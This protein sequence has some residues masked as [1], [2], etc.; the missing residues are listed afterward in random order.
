MA[1]YK[2]IIELDRELSHEEMNELEIALWAQCEDYGCLN[3]QL[4]GVP[5]QQTEATRAVPNKG[6]QDEPERGSF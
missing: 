1:M 5:K 6:A 4:V 3:A 2:F